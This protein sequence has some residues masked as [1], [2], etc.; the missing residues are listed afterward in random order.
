MLV[1]N[2]EQDCIISILKQN[3]PSLPPILQVRILEFFLKAGVVASQV[4][5]LY[6]FHV[7]K[8]MHI[9]IRQH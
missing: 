9:L 3:F 1:K 6:W 5:C 2:K 7:L 4:S 8:S